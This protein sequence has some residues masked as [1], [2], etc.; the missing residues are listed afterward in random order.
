MAQTIF[1]QKDYWVKS[2]C[3][4]CIHS[5]AIRVHVQD[6]VVVKIEGDP[7]DVNNKGKLCPKGQSGIMRLYDPNRVKTPLKRTNPEKGPGVDPK[8]QPNSWDE[9][10][11]IVATRLKK[12]RQEDPRKL[13]VSINDFHRIHLWGWGAM[14]GSYNYFS[15]VG[16]Y[17]GAAYHP[18]NG[19]LDGSFAAVNDYAYCNY[20]IQIGGGDGFSSHLHVAGSI[21]RMAEARVDRGM[22]VVVVEPRM[23]TGAAKA[24]EWVPIL[25]GTD[26]AFVLGMVYVLLHELNIYDAEFLKI[27]TNG[28]YLI[29]PDGY[30]V[31]DPETRKP[32]I[33]DTGANEAKQFDDPSIEDFALEGNYTVNG[34]KCRPAFQ[35]IKDTLKDHT[36]ERMSKICTVPADTIRRIAQEYG[37]AARIGSTIVI[38]GKEYP[39]RPAAVNYYRGAIGHVDGGLDS[40]ALKLIN[41]LAGNIDVPGGHIGVGLDHRLLLTEPG[42]DGMLLPQPHILHPPYPFADKP[43]SFQLMEWYP[44]GIDP[45]HLSADNILNPE[46]WGFDF[47]PEALIIE[48]SNPMWNLSSTDKVMEV[49]RQLDFIVAIDVVLNES[50][51]WADIVLPD[52]TYLESH[53]LVDIEPPVI[54]GH[55]YRRPVIEPLYDSRDASDIFTDLAERIGF[56]PE[57]N[58]LMNI[59][60][61]LTGE[62][63]LEP[64]KK[65]TNLELM[66]RM[67]KSIYGSD[68]GLDWFQENGHATRYQK[69]EEMYLPWKGLRIPLYFNF[70]KEVGDDLKQKTEAAGLDWDTSSY[71]PIPVWRD[72]HP[73]HNIAPEYD[74]YAF[75]FKETLLNF[76]ESTTIPW[77]NEAMNNIPIHMGV[78][79]NTKTAKAKGINNGDRI[80]VQSPFGEVI[81]K[82]S[83][84]E[85]IHPQVIG[86]S[87]GISRWTNHPIDKKTNTHFN[88]LLP[89]DVKWTD[90]MTGHLET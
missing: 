79:I 39:Y 18:V 38:E 2:A 83:V 5:C 51:E 52:H 22:K 10:L 16:Q 69:P 75:A 61:F 26:R 8:W 84:I 7:N 59:K 29:G 37:E 1:K 3:K 48:H 47:K 53:L 25:P 15:T 31:R 63:Q 73:L 33:W 23:S 88:R 45:G 62:N 81:G 89:A 46:K 13:L 34:M 30:F 60:L 82:A 85:E 49:F 20:W 43:Y 55:V 90:G 41:I 36:P 19:T 50:T 44:I 11:D 40:A 14:F 65:Y 77:I 80:R 57:W 87:N 6:G 66:D 21:K 70:F 9:A 74:L 56:L 27:H 68:K 78:I 64:N 28:P 12:V 35:V 24:D 54:T 86:M 67:A 42:P 72:S 4:M 58:G 32:L 17:C 71:L 76:S